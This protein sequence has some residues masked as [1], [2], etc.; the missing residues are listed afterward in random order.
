MKQL[1]RE[2]GREVQQLSMAGCY[3]LSG[4]TVEHVARCRGLVKVN[5]AGCNLTS[6]RLSKVLSALQH[7]RSLAIDVSPGFDASQLSSECKA[8]LS[9]VR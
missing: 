7:L 3:W 5:L 6:L 8:T 1:V 9:R 4:A 2:I